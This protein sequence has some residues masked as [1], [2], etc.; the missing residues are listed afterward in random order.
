MLGMHM[1]VLVPPFYIS[2]TQI[3]VITTRMMCHTHV[4][5]TTTHNHLHPQTPTNISTPQKLPRCCSSA[6]PASHTW[7]AAV[8]ISCCAVSASNPHRDTVAGEACMSD[9]HSKIKVTLLLSCIHS[10][11]GMVR[12]LVCKYGGGRVDMRVCV[13]MY[14]NCECI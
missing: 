9:V 5:I 4:H 6:T 7:C 12:R 10:P 2:H 11:E 13:I 14:I 1:I 3:L 8:A